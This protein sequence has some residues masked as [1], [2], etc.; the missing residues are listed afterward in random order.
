MFHKFRAPNK[1]TLVGILLLASHPTTQAADDFETTQFKF[2]FTNITQYH[3]PFAERLPAGYDETK[4]S[5]TYP[6]YSLTNDADRSYTR[7]LTGYFGFRP[8]ANGEFYVNPEIT[9]GVPFTNN[10]IGMGG[11]YN[12][13]ITR[14]AG[15]QP[16]LYRQR[17]FFRQTWNQGGGEEKIDSDLNWMAGTVDK[18]RIVLTVGN[19]SA[20][21]VFDKNTYS[22]DPRRQFMNWGHMNNLAW[23]YAADARGFGWGFATEWYQGDWVVRFGR[24]TGPK[25][26]NMLPVDFNLTKHYGDQIEIEHDHEIG[27]QPGAVRLI[28]YRNRARLASF[29]DAIRYGDA[30]GWQP[31]PNNGMEYILNVRGAEK[32]KFGIGVNMEQALSNNLGVFLKA[33]WSDG[34]TETYAFGEVDRSISTGMSIKGG[35]WNRSQDTLGISFLSHFLSR[36]RREYLEKGGVSFFIGD[37]WLRYRPEQIFE[38]YYSLSLLPS[39]WVTGDIQRVWHPAYNADRGPVNILG[40]RLHAEF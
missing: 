12:G 8:W 2:Q 31:D 33:M 17:V 18:N 1:A 25:E 11:F 14:A 34:R 3:R 40:L 32:I 36:D 28:A 24:M 16:K 21:D 6:R 38:T 29:R 15:T 26:P 5:G 23:D 37:G 35:Y 27:D 22:N 30:N 39:L 19:F 20:L 9:Q 4:Y 10:L 13:E 7:T